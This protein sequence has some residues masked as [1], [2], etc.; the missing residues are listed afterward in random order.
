[1]PLHNL[2]KYDESHGCFSGYHYPGMSLNTTVRL[3]ADSGND[4]VQ[5]ND[6]AYFV[7]PD[8]ETSSIAIPYKLCFRFNKHYVCKSTGEYASLFDNTTGK[9]R[10]SDKA[11]EL[12]EQGYDMVVLD[13][14]DASVPKQACLFNP[15]E[16]VVHV[17]LDDGEKSLLNTS[18]DVATTIKELV[19][20]IKKHN[21]A[22]YVLD[23]PLVPDAFYDQKYRLLQELESKYPELVL[24]DSPTKKVGGAVQEGFTSA[25]HTAPM[26]SIHTETSPS[27]QALMDW[28][29]SLSQK[30]NN[31]PVDTIPE[32]KFDG[33]SLS[34]DYE[35]GKLTRALTRG[36]GEDGEVVT[37]NAKYVFGIPISIPNKA[38]RLTV[39]G[40]V[41]MYK[42]DFQ[43]LNNYQVSRGAKPF[44]NPRNAA[45]G[46]LRQLDPKVTAARKLRFVAYSV[47]E[48]DESLGVATQEGLLNKLSGLG[49]PTYIV[50]NFHD[51]IPF[52]NFLYIQDI[53]DDLPFEID[54]VVFKVDSL[55]DQRE[56]GFRSR[57]PYWAI[58]YK[59]PPQEAVTKLLAIDVQVGRTG[60]LTPVAR[61]EPVF[62]SGT[63]VSNV[64]LHN[65]FDLRLR[66]IRVGDAIVVRRA[67]DVIPE[68]TGALKDARKCYLPNFHMP[69]ACPVCGGKVAREKGEREYRCTNNLSCKAQLKQ[70]LTHFASKRAMDINGL[71][72]QL[73]SQ[74]VDADILTS[75]LDIYNLTSEKL[76]DLPGI[77]EKTINNLLAAI[78]HS[79][80]VTFARFI[81]SL[82][83]RH[84]GESTAKT[85]AEHYNHVFVLADASIDL[86]MKMPDVGDVVARSIHD[87]FRN[88]DNYMLAGSL[89]TSY[90]VIEEQATVSEKLKGKVFVFTGSFEGISRDKMK[91]MVIIHGGKV[92]GTLSSKVTYLVVGN[93]PGSK[94]DDAEKLKVDMI[95]QDQFM[96]MV[97]HAD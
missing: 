52:N 40:E 92:S 24:P 44:A 48:G 3:G 56:L 64:T 43:E 82:G 14:F 17:C 47:V 67:G 5:S 1:M 21:H 61:L 66:G 72:D 11:G 12:M 19:E 45:A 30:L 2:F 16:Q 78:E 86:L 93:D 32:Y 76:L 35:K 20:E 58:A 84:V 83:I 63:T 49:F 54:G 9:V 31:K 50:P 23:K 85:I 37:E 90:L 79:K 95:N 69:K 88:K 33:V 34:L 36:D 8:K 53:R 28:K 89:Q 80:K 91:E 46:S 94:V 65:V 42:S 39:R 29:A 96:Q 25:K 26:L 38:D 41:M 15:D 4:Y 59:F 6:R 73:I 97:Q 7:L 71:G 87:F 74:L 62:V 68:I 77:G 55:A 75:A 18:T 27:E 51:R 81:F 22:Y 10:L 60:K 13:S 70:S 57:E